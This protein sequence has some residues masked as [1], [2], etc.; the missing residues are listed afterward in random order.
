MS[1][2]INYYFMESAWPVWSFAS[3][4]P[5]VG[6]LEQV[7]PS[8]GVIWLTDS[9]GEVVTLIQQS[10]VCSALCCSSC[11]SVT[12]SSD[13][14]MSDSEVLVGFCSPFHVSFLHFSLQRNISDFLQASSYLPTPFIPNFQTS[15]IVLG[16]PSTPLRPTVLLNP[17]ETVNLENRRG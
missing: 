3:K 13:C 7:V 8:P 15:T 11:E 10:G 4:K 1:Y 14:T 6:F 16:Q 17:T 12:L 5:A 2:P 9:P